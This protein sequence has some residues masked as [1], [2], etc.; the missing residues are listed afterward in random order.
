MGDSFWEKKKAGGCMKF[1]LDG[2]KS[3][4]P[5]FNVEKFIEETLCKKME[6]QLQGLVSEVTHMRDQLTET[7]S[8]LRELEEVNSNLRKLIEIQKKGAM[9][10]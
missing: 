9:Y 2:A 6:V 8:H 3:L 1:L 5:T 10:E 7:N 4:H